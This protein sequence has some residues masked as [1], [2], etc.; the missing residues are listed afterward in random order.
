MRDAR[1]QGGVALAVVVWFIAGMS[2]L[3]AGVVMTAR[4]DVR[5]AQIHLARAEVTAAGDG[6]INL[7][8]ADLLDQESAQSAPRDGVFDGRFRLGED[9]VRVVAVSEDLMVNVN[10][11]SAAD[12]GSAIIASG[13][14]DPEAARVLAR[15]VVNFRDGRS[16]DGRT[17]RQ[18]SFKALE[19]LLSVPG[20]NRAV[21]D[22][23]R[24]YLV[25]YRSAGAAVSG[26]GATSMSAARGQQQKLRGLAPETR[27]E[28]PE[29]AP[30]YAGGRG[31]ES[32]ALAGL[33]RIDAMVRR[34]S[35]V[36][37]RRRWARLGTGQG[38]LPWQFTRTEPV[39]MVARQQPG[40]TSVN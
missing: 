37:L 25:V 36:W 39:R 8:M 3:V 2:L 12:I 15:S 38:S 9:F 20:F 40:S 29:L 10:T 22:A 33:L 14:V 31:S 13:Q 34:G 7:L 23:A 6:A 19:D 18:G 28:H 1:H 30:S 26:A 16:R 32:A 5:L 4:T 35:D 24:D 17:R 27:A 21:L 11:A